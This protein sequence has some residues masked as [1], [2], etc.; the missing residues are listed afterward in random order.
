M[1]DP[2]TAAPQC[3]L[4]ADRS[5]EESRSEEGRS[6][7]GPHQERRGWYSRGYLPHFDSPYA[8]QHITYRLADALPRAVVEE[9]KEQREQWKRTHDLNNLSREELAEYHRLFSERYETLLNAGSGSCV[10]RDPALAQI[11]H[12]A[13]RFF[14]G[15]RYVL[16]EYVVMPNHVHVLVK[17]LAAHGLADILH[18]WKSFTANRINARLG[19]AGQLWQHESYD[20]ILRNENAMHAVRN[21]IRK[22]PM[23]G[24]SILLP[25]S[26]AR[27]GCSRHF[28][29]TMTAPTHQQRIT[30]GAARR[31]TT[32][33]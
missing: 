11:V 24:G 6:Q 16:D 9:M 1:S 3:G 14:D 19:R 10:L 26:D 15:Q 18:S 5:A 28:G 17:P 23:V 8:I 32:L 12:G 25:Y 29:R 27:A 13:L 33:P 31:P 22:N 30:H 7:Q 21:Y 20:H 2:G 4:C